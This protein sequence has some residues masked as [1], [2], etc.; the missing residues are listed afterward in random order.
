MKK[1]KIASNLPLTNIHTTFHYTATILL[2]RT[3]VIWQKAES[4]WQVQK[5]LGGLATIKIG[6]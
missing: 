4:L 2:S 5:K 1:R 3:K 6:Q